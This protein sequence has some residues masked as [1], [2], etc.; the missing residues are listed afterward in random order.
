MIFDLFIS[1][2]SSDHEY[3]KAMREALLSIDPNL[4]IFWSEKTLEEIGESDY[5]AAIENAITNS[6][7]MVVV[8]SSLSNI[9]SKWVS[10]EWKLFK[11]LQLNDSEHFYNNLFLATTNISITDLPISLQICEC[12]GVDSYETIYKYAK[13]NFG[14]AYRKKET[15]GL[16]ILQNMLSEVGWEDSTFY[17]PEYL[18]QYELK[19]ST[20]LQNV[21]IISHQLSQDSPGGVLW[22]TVANNLSNGIN[23][24]Y[25]FLDSARAY[26][27]LRK[28]KNGHSE[29]NRKRLLLEVAE[30]SFWALGSYSNV[31]IYEFKNGRPSEGYI[32]IKINS[33]NNVEYPVYLRMSEQFVDVLWNHIGAFRASGKIKEYVG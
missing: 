12:L 21:T 29:D 31:T 25:I 30:D 3:A 11:H 19:I 10:Y 23:Y 18:S 9:T 8:G 6:K 32:R 24:N 15:K 16:S 26:G 13:S 17:S 27:T 7:N 20:D 22:D 1:Y 5:T 14:D 28:I 4:N 33:K 2:K